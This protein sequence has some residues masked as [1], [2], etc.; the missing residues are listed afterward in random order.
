MRDQK[1]VASRRAIPWTENQRARVR[2]MGQARAGTVTHT[3]IR[4]PKSSFTGRTR[5]GRGRRRPSRLAS[6]GKVSWQGRR[7]MVTDIAAPMIRRPR[8]GGLPS[9][10]DKVSMIV[11]HKQVR[12]PSGTA[13][14]L[15][16]K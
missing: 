7:A 4:T 16:D 3:A 13:G 1:G 5:M 10:P 15:L 14:G 9:R 2:V 11:S 12:V 6:G 8:L